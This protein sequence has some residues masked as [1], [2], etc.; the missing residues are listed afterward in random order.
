M[1]IGIILG[2]IGG[3]WLQR[4]I[5]DYYISGI[6]DG[7]NTN[8]SPMRVSLQYRNR[9]NIDASL[10]LVAT[11]TNANITID[12]P[13][14]WIWCNGT[15]AKIYVGATSHM[16][17]Y[18]SYT[19]NVYPVGNPQNFTVRYTIEDKSDF[20]AIPNGMI[21]HLFAEWHGYD[22]TYALYNRTDTNIYQLVKPSLSP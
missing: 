3:G 11:V 18:G 13:E 14:S 5:V 10:Y 20:W 7:Y 17:D 21:S 2:L 4:P 22:P 6:E 16:D 8:W 9:G 1:I 15:Q 19:I 12:K